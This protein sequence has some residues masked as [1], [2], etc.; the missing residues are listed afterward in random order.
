LLVPVLGAIVGVLAGVFAAAQILDRGV[1]APNVLRMRE[2]VAREQILHTMPTASVS[3]VRVYS[4]RVAPGR[5]VR[6]RP[7]PDAKLQRGVEVTL[8][9]SK[10]TPFAQVPSIASGTAPEAAKANLER[11][12]FAARYRW[13]P[14]WYVRKGTVVELSP[15]AGMRVR[16]P[17]TV[18][19][20]ISSGWPRQVVPDLSGFDVEA[21]KQEL[22]AKHLRYGIVYRRTQTA[23]ADQVLAQKPAAGA[24]VYR[25][26]RIWLGVARRV[27]WKK[28]ISQSGSGSFESV[29]FT[30]PVKW[31]IRYRLD[32]GD[33]FG[34]STEFAWTR[35]GDLFSDDSFFADQTGA[36]QVHDVSD[37][38][39]TYRLSVHPYGSGVSWY[40][41]VDAL[42]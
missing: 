33:L 16:R 24:T 29:P 2:R 36:M 7:R 9:V 25:G 18:R 8:L 34:A 41:E 12:G 11:S 30:V 28:V 22:V 6:Q 35:D 13:T 32:G 31:R 3:V 10:G 42:Q 20:V 26:T 40:V 21:A 1:H 4:T 19:I 37:G 14:S 23:V 5:V 17:A 39:G 27:R 15:G 38:G